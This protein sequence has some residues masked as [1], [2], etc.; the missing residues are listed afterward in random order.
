MNLN[1]L[2]NT[3]LE[4]A[5]NTRKLL[6]ENKNVF[7]DLVE[8]N[9]SIDNEYKELN[10]SIIKAQN[11]LKDNILSYNRLSLEKQKME[12]CIRIVN[13]NK[14]ELDQNLHQVKD[15]CISNEIEIDDLHGVVDS[16]NYSMLGL[17]DAVQQQ[18]RIKIEDIE[19]SITKSAMV[20]ASMSKAFAVL[21]NTSVSYTCPVCL[22]HEVEIYLDACGHTMCSKCVPR[23]NRCYFCR[24]RFIKHNKLYFL[25]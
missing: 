22:T 6:Y 2:L 23:D 16:I 11:I 3:N 19:K 15:M 9:T 14:F 25:S 10:D 24:A 20:L 1:Q 17:T 12:D 4:D 18:F 21:K 5:Y 13:N 7:Y 8:D